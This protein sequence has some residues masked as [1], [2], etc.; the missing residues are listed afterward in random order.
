VSSAPTSLALDATTRLVL[1]QAPRGHG[2]RVNVDAIHL[3]RF[4][5]PRARG[6]LVDLGA[7]NGAVGLATAL[8][9]P[10]RP[11][12]IVL[13]ERESSAAALAATNASANDVPAEVL[14]VDVAVAAR[15]LRGVAG[16]VVCN[17]PYFEIGRARPRKEDAVAPGAR[18]GRLATFAAA[19][20][21]ILGQ[22]GRAFF[23]Y[24]AP[25]LSRALASFEAHGLVAKRARFVH[26]RARD[27]ARIVLLELC[28]GK[29][30]GLVIEPAAL[31]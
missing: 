8:L 10:A 29:S 27:P 13:V 5:A 4:A 20:R 6:T 15:A 21:T 11:R 24:P 30:G 25:D 14:S 7:G 9:C 16:S 23:V 1:H 28:A 19:A 22:R 18:L 26:G 3:A 12:R 2:Y 17:P 31:D